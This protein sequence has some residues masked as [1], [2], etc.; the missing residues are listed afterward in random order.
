[1]SSCGRIFVSSSLLL[2]SAPWIV[3]GSDYVKYNA[4]LTLDLE[5]RA[6]EL[7]EKREV[8]SSHKEQEHV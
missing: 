4:N 6:N 8:A 7:R 3:T 2:C 5:R 1:M